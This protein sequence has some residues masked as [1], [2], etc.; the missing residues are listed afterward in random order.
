MPS[1]TFPADCCD[2]VIHYGEQS[3]IVLI[4]MMHFE[5]TSFQANDDTALKLVIYTPVQG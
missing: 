1:W 4:L 5:H 3:L 2:A